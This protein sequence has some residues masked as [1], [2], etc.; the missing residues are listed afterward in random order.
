MSVN[1]QPT[2]YDY[3]IVMAGG[4]EPEVYGPVHYPPE[5]GFPNTEGGDREIV[6]A[7]TEAML[8]KLMRSHPDLLAKPGEDNAF[9]ITVTLNPAGKPR[10]SARTWTGGYMDWLRA[11]C[12]GTT[13][14]A[15]YQEFMA[16]A[17]NDRA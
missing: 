4:I 11:R 9:G 1:R 14:A 16:T 6:E 7:R 8:M 2:E 13:R 3:V 12:E 10:V 5:P 17:G 15:T